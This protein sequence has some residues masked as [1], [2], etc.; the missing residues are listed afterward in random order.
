M[1]G[2]AEVLPSQIR[3]M[4]KPTRR[5]DLLSPPVLLSFEPFPSGLNGGSDAPT[6]LSVETFDTSG[7]ERSLHAC[8]D[9]MGTE[10]TVFFLLFEAPLLVD[11]VVCDCT[12]QEELEHFLCCVTLGNG[13]LTCAAK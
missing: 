9:W 6:E 12:V 8:G 5:R 2:Q 3:G 1:D 7:T 11:L 4:R 10:S 13:H